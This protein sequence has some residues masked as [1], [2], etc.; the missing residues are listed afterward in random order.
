MRDQAILEFL[1]ACGARISEASNLKLGDVDFAQ[2][3]VKVFGKGRE[4]AYNPAA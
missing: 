3:Q 1:Y 2:G 4:R